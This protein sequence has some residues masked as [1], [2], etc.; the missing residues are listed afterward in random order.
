MW[1]FHATY[2]YYFCL[3]DPGAWFFEATQDVR[4]GHSALPIRSIHWGLCIKCKGNH[5]GSTA[6]LGFPSIICGKNQYWKRVL[7]PHQSQGLESLNGNQYLVF[8]FCEGWMNGFDH[9]LLLHRKPGTDKGQHW[10]ARQVQNTGD[11]AQT[12]TWDTVKTLGI[13]G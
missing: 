13:R 9:H 5:K 11:Q 3:N 6:Y 1:Y 10:N 7:H 2:W 8:N 4:T 12:A